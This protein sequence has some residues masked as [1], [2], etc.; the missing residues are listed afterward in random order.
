MKMWLEQTS[1]LDRDALHIYCAVAIQF[2]LAIF[3]RRGVASFWPWVAVLL[4]VLLNEY[5]D[6][7]GVGTDAHQIERFRQASFHDIWNTM[8]L[9][10]MLLIIARYWPKWLVGAKAKSDELDTENQSERSV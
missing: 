1:G 4:A 9:P 3:L 5:I 10:T 6:F 7:Q 2:G 8:L